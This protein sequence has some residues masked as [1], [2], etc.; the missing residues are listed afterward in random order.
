MEIS[1]ITDRMKVEA[2][3]VEVRGGGG[4]LPAVGILFLL[5][6]CG[7]IAA[8]ACG[9]SLAADNSW[10]FAV[11][12]LMCI[13][14]GVVL[15]FG[16]YTLLIDG[17][18]R[19]Y[20]KRFSVLV[21]IKDTGGSLDEFDKVVVS[22][23]VQR[24]DSKTY[25]DYPVQLEGPA[26]TLELATPDGVENARRDA[27]QVAKALRLPLA[28]R[29]GSTE[30]VREADHLDESLRQ[31]RHRTGKGPG[32]LER[33]WIGGEDQ[34]PG[35]QRPHDDRV[36]PPLVARGKGMD[37]DRAGICADR[38]TDRPFRSAAWFPRRSLGTR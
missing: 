27:E 28:D 6:G 37:Q 23:R 3:R 21:T 24:H 10:V 29:T 15:T 35:S 7:G 2:G 34:D 38:M 31:R 17:N 18:T 1:G 20:R 33:G 30:I 5:A 14:P 9:D 13:V 32:E 8:F 36:W 12:G 11:V 25:T 16:R 22:R 19:T 26:K 4:C